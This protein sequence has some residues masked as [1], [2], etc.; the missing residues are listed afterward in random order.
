M[1][2]I[3]GI[4]LKHIKWWLEKNIGK[5]CSDYEWSCVVCRAWRLFDSIKGYEE[6]IK[7]IDEVVTKL[8]KLK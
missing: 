8:K 3:K 4:N 1:E 5:R 6:Y 7:S 2:I